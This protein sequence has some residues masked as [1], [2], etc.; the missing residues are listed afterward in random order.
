MG[1]A[2]P[3]DI[4]KRAVWEAYQ[5]VKANR[6]A[7]GVDDQS[8][9]DFERDV[10]NNLFKLWN[11]L[12][13]GSYFPPP[14][15]RVAIKKRQ[16]GTR[17]L[18]IPTVSDRIA[19]G[20]VKAYLEPE[21][22][23]HFHPDS[24]GYRPGKSA[25]EAVGMA[26][27]RCWRHDWV[28]DLDIQAFFDT[29]PHDLLLRAVRKHTDCTWV[30]LYIERWLTAPVQL[31]NGTLE[32]RERGTPQGSVISPL[33]ANLFLHYAFDRWMAKHR[34][35]IP[36]ERFADDAVCHCSSERQ[37]QKLQT[38]LEQRFAEC[39]LKLHPN[40]TQI[41]YC[42][43]N[44]RRGHCPNQK[45]DFLGYTFRP[46]LAMNRWG[47]TFVNFSPGI[48][49]RAAKAIRQTMRDWQLDRRIDKR[50]NDLAKMFNPI[51]RGWMN[52]Y[53]RYH[54][55]ALSR[56][57]MHLDLRLARWAM[58]KYRRLRRHRRRARY[59]VQ[60][61]RRREPALFAHWRLLYRATAGR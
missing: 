13:S 17:P 7:A 8:I 61:V 60:D 18:G 37:A 45:F 24:Y 25:L 2:K 40:K 26:R 57:L 3:F 19:Q 22:E 42:K 10:K 28:L 33:L 32:P 58:S 55:S 6:G 4:P 35:E 44:V 49:N 41:V 52:Y 56:A 48:S 59:W 36:F 54:K 34:P 50:I 9:E 11:R 5:R 53:G 39:G 47:K 20:V 14:V 15:K 12:S 43:D 27:Q 31:E 51:L 1:K 21:L 30:L 23:R 46:R 16:G 29:I 38:D